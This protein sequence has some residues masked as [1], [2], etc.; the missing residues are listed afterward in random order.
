MKKK[1]KN[2]KI[3]SM[4]YEFKKLKRHGS[5]ICSCYHVFDQ[6]LTKSKH[7]VGITR[8]RSR[9]KPTGVIRGHYQKSAQ[10]VKLMTFFLVW[11][12]ITASAACLKSVNQPYLSPLELTL[13][14]Y[15]TDTLPQLHEPY[16]AFRTHGGLI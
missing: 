8:R 1:N 6:R 3:M 9:T 7:D 2:E 16:G 12:V 11:L 15:R 13:C 14:C 4:N 10:C 5:R